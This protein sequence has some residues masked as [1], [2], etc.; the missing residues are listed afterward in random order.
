MIRHILAALLLLS[1]GAATGYG[2]PQFRQPQHDLVGDANEPVIVVNLP[3]RILRLYIDGTLTMQCP[4][5]IGRFEYPGLTE[6]TMTRCGSY[7]I[8]TWV[9]GHTTKDHLIPWQ[10]SQWK[11]AFGIHTALL[12]PGALYQH[13]HGTVGPVEL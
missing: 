7:R 12:G 11:G 1:L 6:N 5:A 13:I 10:K 4:V 9:K 8:E 3:A 2:R